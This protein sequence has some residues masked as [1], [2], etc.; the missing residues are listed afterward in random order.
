MCNFEFYFSKRRVSGLIGNEVLTTWCYDGQQIT[1]KTTY[2]RKGE[3]YK[4]QM[5]GIIFISYLMWNCFVTPIWV[6][7]YIIVHYDI[8]SKTCTSQTR[9]SHFYIPLQQTFYMYNDRSDELSVVGAH[10]RRQEAARGAL[11]PPPDCLYMYF[12]SIFI[13]LVYVLCFSL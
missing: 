11:A 9:V 1:C 12:S 4:I 13:Y 3:D 10:G 5:Q 2:Y 8:S 7:C 6:L